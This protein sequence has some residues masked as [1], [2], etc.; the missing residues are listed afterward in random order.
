MSLYLG[1]DLIDAGFEPEDEIVA[2][3]VYAMTGNEDMSELLYINI[4]TEVDSQTYL[5]YFELQRYPF[6]S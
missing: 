3:S 1:S 2:D 6:I 4:E 5:S